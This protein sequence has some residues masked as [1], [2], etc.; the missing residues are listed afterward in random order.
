MHAL[1]FDTETGGLDPQEHSL[2]TAY[3]CI[4]D[5]KEWKILDELD[6]KLKPE[7]GNFIITPKAMEING[8]DLK[9]HKEEAI[10]YKEGNKL[11]KSFLKKNKIKGKR[12]H[13][14]PLGQNIGFD[15]NFLKAQVITDEEWKKSGIY[16]GQL[17]TKALV[18]FLKI[19]GIF[20]D[21]MKT[22]LGAIIDYLGLPKRDAHVA[23]DDVLMTIDVFRALVDLFKENTKGGSS[24][25]TKLILGAIE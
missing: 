16:Y 13:F 11:L 7:D 18:D 24:L 8:I 19:V 1:V 9:K 10:T 23:K 6:L 17:D 3:F 20:P 5:L 4:L 21:Y 2:L 14:I 12:N 15:I 25:S 22:N